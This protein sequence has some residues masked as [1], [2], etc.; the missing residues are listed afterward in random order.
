MRGAFDLIFGHVGRLS[1]CK[2][3]MALLGG[4]AE[5]C[6]WRRW[7]ANGVGGEKIASDLTERKCGGRMLGYSSVLSSS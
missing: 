3:H 7:R 6:F 2:T 1:L 4:K 5:G